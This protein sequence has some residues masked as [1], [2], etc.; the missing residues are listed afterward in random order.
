MIPHTSTR[1]PPPQ[2]AVVDESGGPGADTV[3][4]GKT[5]MQHQSQGLCEAMGMV[6]TMHGNV[7]IGSLG[8]LLA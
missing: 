8:L 2:P 4:D 7:R 5:F 3:D 1:D 6:A